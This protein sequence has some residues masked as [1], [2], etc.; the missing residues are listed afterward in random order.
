MVPFPFEFLSFPLLGLQFDLFSL[1]FCIPPFR[2]FVST[3]YNQFGRGGN[4][5]QQRAAA[6]AA[7][8]S[9][10]GL[11]SKVSNLGEVES[12]G[13]MVKVVISQHSYPHDAGHSQVSTP[14]KHSKID[15]DY[16]PLVVNCKKR[17]IMCVK[18]KLVV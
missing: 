7:R 18:P 8:T 13:A 17:N 14:I 12:E 3:P 9:E 4:S 1:S 6:L 10:G 2:C 16:Q 5:H 15:K 11:R